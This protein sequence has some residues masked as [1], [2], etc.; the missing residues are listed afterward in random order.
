[1][2]NNEL[3]QIEQAQQNGTA[4]VIRPSKNIK[5]H[6]ME[7]DKKVLQTVYDLGRGDALNLL[8]ELRKF[9]KEAKK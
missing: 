1:M 5:I 2:Y 7:T 8:P 4:F 6:H 9:L 3:K